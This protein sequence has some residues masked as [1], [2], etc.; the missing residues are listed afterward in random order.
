[1]LGVEGSGMGGALPCLW[2]QFLLRGKQLSLCRAAIARFLDYFKKSLKSELRSK[3]FQSA[4][5][6][7]SLIYF[8]E[9]SRADP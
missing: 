2:G 6:S 7:D 9:K 4:K 1:M 8:W 5:V 3:I